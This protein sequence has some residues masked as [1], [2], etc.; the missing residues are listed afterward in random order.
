[1]GAIYS[2]IITGSFTWTE[3]AGRIVLVAAAFII[4]AI[5]GRFFCGFICSFGAMQDLVW[6]GGKH[7]PRKIKV[8]EKADRILKLLKFAVLLFVIIGV[9]TFSVTGT[10][11][12]SPWTIFG[13]YATFKGFPAASY[14]LS[15]GGLLMLLILIG[16]FFI[17]RF[18]CKYL[19]PLGA[20]YSLAAKLRIFKIKKPTAA[21]GNCCLCAS[22]CSMS[23]PMNKYDSI[24]SGECINCMRCTTV[25]RRNNV[26][27]NVMPA[28]SGTAVAAA[29]MGV[30]F[31]GDMMVNTLPDT[32]DT[33]VSN[34]IVFSQDNTVGQYKDGTYQ[35]TGNGFRGNIDLTVTVSGG[36]IT[37]ITVN[38]SWD[39]NEFFSCA[40]SKVIPAIIAAQDVNVSTVSGATFS[41]KGILEAVTNALGD[42]LLQND[43]STQTTQPSTEENPTDRPNKHRNQKPRQ[44][45]EESSAEESSESTS[46]ESSESSTESV[47]EMTENSEHEES[48]E[49]S[50]SVSRTPIEES[51]YTEPEESSTVPQESSQPEESSAEESNVSNGAYADGVYTGSGTGFR[52]TTTASVTVSGGS[53][54]DITVTSYQDDDRFF[55]QAQNSIIAAVIANQSTSV[56]TVSGATFS[57]NG[58]IEAISNALGVPFTNPNSTMTNH[59][60][61]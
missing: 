58:L 55:H 7:M 26:K 48:S 59:H 37:D 45:F 16:S 40:E 31:V 22:Q 24:A 19:C 28:V 47:P 52:G 11:L 30:Y 50:E 44:S 53:I 27:A 41:S 18:F 33:M 4:T 10:T 46:A 5:W 56:S 9:W 17:E 14:L 38:S 2:A 3:Y 20:L 54:T 49:S 6:L 61:R 51:S 60:R 36:K 29:L 8:P 23:V 34:E 39:D 25:C 15:I 35:G 57:S 21:C 42:Q 12:W 32:Y 13:M 43:T 1:M